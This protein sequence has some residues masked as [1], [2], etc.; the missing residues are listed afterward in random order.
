MIID[1]HEKV[2]AFLPEVEDG[3]TFHYTELV[4]CHRETGEGARQRVLKRFF[5]RSQAHFL[6]QWETIRRLAELNQVRAYIRLSP[7]SY[8][9]VGK[10]FTA[11]IVHAA[12]EEQWRDMRHMY[13]SA[14]KRVTPTKKLWLYDIDAPVLSPFQPLERELLR[15]DVLVTVIPSRTG[16]HVIVKPHHV[17]YDPMGATLHKDAPTNLYIPEGAV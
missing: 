12:L 14:C 17:T 8:R 6:E 13:E 1:N 3:D 10:L 16:H 7:R 15:L 11:K 5:H 2:A 9:D 4:D